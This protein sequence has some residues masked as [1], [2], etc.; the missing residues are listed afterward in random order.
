MCRTER[1]RAA[2][3]AP[4][5]APLVLPSSGVGHRAPQARVAGETLSDMQDHAKATIA[6]L[7]GTGKEGAGLAL[8]WAHAG[9]SRGHRIAL[10]GARHAD[11]RGNQRAPSAQRGRGA[12]EQSRRRSR[13]D[14]VVL[15][16][17]YAAQLATLGEV[18]GATRPARSWST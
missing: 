11:R 12:S 5:L 14:I 15:T 3:D 17:P 1:R 13:A 6:V 7:G 8:R 2:Y 9:Y 4:E 16:V 18:E 10:A